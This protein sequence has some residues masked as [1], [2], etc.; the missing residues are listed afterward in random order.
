METG[1]FHMNPD[2]TPGDHPSNPV[3]MRG[4]VWT[5]AAVE[6]VLNN[7]T[8]NVLFARELHLSCAGLKWHGLFA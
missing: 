7:G 3:F 1:V 4:E 8:Y 2:T 5:R 6:D